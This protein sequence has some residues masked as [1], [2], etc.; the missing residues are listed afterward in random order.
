M[1]NKKMRD[2]IVSLIEEIDISYQGV[3][4]RHQRTITFETDIIVIEDLESSYEEIAII[5]GD[6]VRIIAE[7]GETV[8]ELTLEEYYQNFTENW[9]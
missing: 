6:K 1:E 7:D 4:A 9:S 8:S 2:E 5:T 3:K